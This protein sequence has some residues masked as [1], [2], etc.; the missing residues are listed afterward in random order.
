MSKSFRVLWR[1]ELKSH[2]LSPLSYG[3]LTLFLVIMGTGFW[4]TIQAYAQGTAGVPIL[5]V[6]FGESL[7]FWIGMMVMAPVITMRLFAEEKRSGTFET[8]MTAPVTDVQVVMA[9]YAGALT[10]FGLMWMPT[11]FYVYV[12]ARFQPAAAPVDM[13]ALLNT[14]FGIL[15]TGS[16]YLSVGLFA[17]SMTK[18]QVVSA[19]TSFCLLLIMFFAG[20][21]PYYAPSATI[22]EITRY[23]S[24][25][26]HMMEFTRGEFDTRPVVLFVSLTALFLFLTVKVVESRQW[27]A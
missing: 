4:M 16:F 26:Y 1:R 9:K 25:I 13:G 2:L 22:Q 19:M 21:L 18:N 24:A 17:S 23:L 3:V 27:K 11:G 7:F 14:F 15:L 8:L 10:F 6:L 20:F 12:L 5:R